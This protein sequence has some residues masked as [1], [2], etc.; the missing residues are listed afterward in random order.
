MS[1]VTLSHKQIT[2]LFQQHHEALLSFLVYRIR[3]P[4]TAQDLCQETYLRLLREGT[5]KHDENLGGFLF[6][7]ADRLALNYL[8]WQTQ[9]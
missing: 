3:C 2:V 9:S 6:R 1:A 5:L 8:K 7:V 4:E